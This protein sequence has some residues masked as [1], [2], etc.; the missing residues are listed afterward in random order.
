MHTPQKPSVFTWLAK[1]GVYLAA[2]IALAVVWLVMFPEPDLS[3]EQTLGG[4]LWITAFIVAGV[5]VYAWATRTKGA[6]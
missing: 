4:P 1:Y 2:A 5:L 3:G 6:P